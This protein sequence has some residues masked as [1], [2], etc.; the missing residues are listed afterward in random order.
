MGRN[1]E[2]LTFGGLHEKYAVQRWFWTFALGPRKN[3]LTF[4]N[5]LVPISIFM[6]PGEN[7]VCPALCL[8]RDLTRVSRHLWPLVATSAPS[9][10]G[11]GCS[12]KE[13]LLVSES[14]VTALYMSLAFPWVHVIP[15]E[16]FWKETFGLLQS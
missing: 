10:V 11:W 3:H 12:R 16:G 8:L 14:C 5:I 15:K 7:Y 6:C 4:F 1:F 2:K 9:T 13:T